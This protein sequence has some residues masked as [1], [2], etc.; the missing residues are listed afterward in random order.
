[1]R[2]KASNQQL[3]GVSLI[4]LLDS[5]G[6]HYSTPLYESRIAPRTGRVGMHHQGLPYSAAIFLTGL[7]ARMLLAA[8]DSMLLQLLLN[9]H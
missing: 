6:S 9:I 2:L 1:M 8:I 7:S 5:V 4:H 3:Y